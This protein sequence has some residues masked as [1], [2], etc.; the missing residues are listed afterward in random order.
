M[1]HLK[2]NSGSIRNS[3]PCLA[4]LTLILAGCSHSR[5]AEE[6]GFTRMFAPQAPAFLNGPVG[7]LLTNSGGFSAHVV[8]ETEDL[9]A[10][11]NGG[12]G[13]LFCQGSKLFFAPEPKGADGKP[14]REAGFGFIWDVASSSGYVL[15]EALQGYAPFT[16]AQ[17]ATNLVV[18]AKGLVDKVGSQESESS[19]I[20]V[21]MSDGSNP[22]FQVWRAMGLNGLPLR[23]TTITNA[24][25]FTI[26]LSNVRLGP[27]PADLFA[28]PN[29]FTKY[30]SPEAM[31]DELA[32]RKLNLRRKTATEPYTGPERPH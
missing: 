3:L 11:Q 4:A 27:A 7:A 2:R 25:A 26:R 30:N 12:S 29:G 18:T 23:I 22:K 6:S 10:R 14:A 9:V 28:P 13:Q 31:V 8:L 16:S 24:V 15:S 19:E 1:E 32:A 5:K 17:R 21:Q 20:T